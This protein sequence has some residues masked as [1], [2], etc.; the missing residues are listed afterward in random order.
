MPE[1]PVIVCPESRY[2]RAP[3]PGTDRAAVGETH[4]PQIPVAVKHAEAVP[5]VCPKSR[6]AAMIPGAGVS[7][8]R[9]PYPRFRELLSSSRWRLMWS[10]VS[11]GGLPT[12]F[13]SLVASTS[14][15]DGCHREIGFGTPVFRSTGGSNVF[16]DC[17]RWCSRQTFVP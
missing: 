6:Y 11:H 13:N 2:R 15:R 4:L 5:A 3:N 16:L 9:V 8:T 17:Q 12:C 10:T 1:L 7:R 14:D